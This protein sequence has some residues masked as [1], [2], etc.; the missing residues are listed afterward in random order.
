MPS[1]TLEGKGEETADEVN[2]N[3]RERVGATSAAHRNPS[4]R[5]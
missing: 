1:H 4:T 2:Q 5:A 3:G